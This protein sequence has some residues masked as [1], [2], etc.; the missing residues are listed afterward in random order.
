[1]ARARRPAAGRRPARDRDPE[2]PARWSDCGKGFLC[3]IRVPRDYH[4]PADGYLNVALVRLSA[5]EPK[6]RIGSLVVNPG[7]PGGSGVEF[8]RQSADVFPAPCASAST[9]SAS[10]RAA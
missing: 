10:I 9:S 6:D 4:D 5:T 1:M 3:A 7:G 2:A 8:V